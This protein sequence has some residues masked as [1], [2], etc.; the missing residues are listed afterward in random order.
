MMAEMSSAQLRSWAK[1]LRH[2]SEQLVPPGA[3]AAIDQWMAD[4]ANTENVEAM[5]DAPPEVKAGGGPYTT[6]RLV[7]SDMEYR[8]EEGKDE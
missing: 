7:A 2:A 3:M 8:A 1:S 6:I 4:P 5:L